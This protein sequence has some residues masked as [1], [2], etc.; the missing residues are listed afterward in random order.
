[1]LSDNKKLN[2][3]ISKQKKFSNKTFGNPQKCNFKIPLLHLKEE[4]DEVLSNPDDKIEWAD[5]LLLFLDAVQR[6]GFSIE[7]I[8]DISHK[9]LKI[10]KKRVWK[11]DSN[12]LYKHVK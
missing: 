3:L 2:T 7:N 9:K 12:G 8:I 6:K 11:K 5:C 1:M 10:N 4:I